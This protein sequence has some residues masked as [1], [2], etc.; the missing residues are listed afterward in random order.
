MTAARPTDRRPA[1]VESGVSTRVRVAIIGGGIIGLACAWQLL[2][3]GCNVTVLDPDVAGGATHAAAGMITPSSE[4]TF[5]QEPLL[6]ASTASASRWPSFAA[7][8]AADSGLPVDLR[9][10]GT[11]FLAAD[12]DDEQVLARQARLLERH[13]RAVERLPGRATRRLEPALS[14]RLAGSL[15]IAD[16]SSVDPRQVARALRVA[17][18][19]RGGEVLSAP[20][21]PLVRDGR[22]IGVER[23]E[24]RGAAGH[25][26]SAGHI[27]QVGTT[28]A[29]VTVMAA[30][31]ATTALAAGLGITVPIRPLK[32]QVLRLRPSAPDVLRHI[33]RACVHGRFVY[34][35]PRPGGEIVVGATSE[36]VGPDSTVTAGAVHDLL[37]DAIELVPELS[38]AALVESITGLRP[39]TPDN[40]PIVGATGI[41]GLVVAAGHGRDGILLA[42][43]TAAA[44]VS[45]VLGSAPPEQADAFTPE[46]FAV[47]ERA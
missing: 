13:H 29:D 45:H 47:K 26:G 43:L 39:A 34:L 3:S 31:W 30:G 42:P 17:I 23:L 5:G 9:R 1:L 4:A 19:R 38:E 8:L 11:L 44:V 22:S 10:A 37:H 25:A 41:D 32:G 7:A 33:V 18:A 35:V 46:R 16:E 40:L 12:H 6:A 14:P 36:D 2:R 21:R 20:A 24:E 27:G 15:L 28:G